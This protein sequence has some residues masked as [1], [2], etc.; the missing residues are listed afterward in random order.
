MLLRLRLLDCE[1]NA[2]DDEREKRQRN[3]HAD[4]DAAEGVLR[5]PLVDHSG[6]DGADDRSQTITAV[7]QQHQNARVARKENRRQ[8]VRRVIESTHSRTREELVKEQSPEIGSCRRQEAANHRY[9]KGKQ[10]DQLE[11]KFLKTQRHS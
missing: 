7:K 10:N 11:T 9:D 3:G 2:S 6:E 5:E 8:R 1:G 4:G